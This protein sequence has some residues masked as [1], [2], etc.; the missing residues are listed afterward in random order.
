MAV[1]ENKLIIHMLAERFQQRETTTAA[2][3]DE[4]AYCYN[5]GQGM[6]VAREALAYFIAKRFLLPY[7]NSDP[8]ITP[9]RAL[10]AVKPKYV[11]LSAGAAPLLNHLFF[12]LGSK[13]DACLIPR[14][15]YAAFETDMNLV[16]GV[17]PIGILQESP[18]AGPTEKELEEA[19]RLAASKCLNPRFLLITNPNNPLG[20]CYRPEVLKRMV[21]WARSR[22]MHVI[23]DEV[24]ALS[25]HRVRFLWCSAEA[26]CLL[27]MH[28]GVRWI[29]LIIHCFSYNNYHRN[30]I[31]AFNQ[32]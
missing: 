28:V 15:Y 24:Y 11:A 7:G 10:E 23:S 8:A 6:P 12:L 32:S 9:D 26:G 16:A 27:S 22:N 29:E 25:T 21:E 19:F 13:G 5:S 17:V 14:P 18:V 2:F 4:A 3:S 20:T 30:M 1:A 31:M